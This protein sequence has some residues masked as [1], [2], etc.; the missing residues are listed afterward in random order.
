MGN[1]WVFGVT[2]TVE[3]DSQSKIFITPF[4][5]TVEIIDLEDAT[6][7]W[8]TDKVGG[9]C[10]LD[11]LVLLVLLWLRYQVLCHNLKD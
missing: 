9:T 11:T 7:H 3:Y 5:F 8:G 10:D 1:I 6:Q 4:Y 2:T